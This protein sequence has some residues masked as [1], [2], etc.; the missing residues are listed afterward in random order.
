M[1]PFI[2]LSILI[3]VL[4]GCAA[5]QASHK[6]YGLEFFGVEMLDGANPAEF[7]IKGYDGSGV[8]YKINAA[9]MDNEVNA[10]AR[11]YGDTMIFEVKNQTSRPVRSHFKADWVILEMDD[12]S[13]YKIGKESLVSA[14]RTKPIRP[15]S[16]RRLVFKIPSGV[17]P[18]NV[19]RM[20]LQLGMFDASQILLKPLPSKSSAKPA[21]IRTRDILGG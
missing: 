13:T 18:F 7:I 14:P 2:I 15:R 8:N 1:K 17:N 21:V 19:R 12:G 3:V 10:H 20:R 9:F 5:P 16:E 4:S 11:V 6:Y